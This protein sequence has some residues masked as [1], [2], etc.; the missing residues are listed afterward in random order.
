MLLCLV[1]GIILSFLGFLQLPEGEISS[2]VLY[3]FN[4][5]LI[6]SGAIF[7]VKRHIKSELQKCEKRD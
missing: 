3:F 5:C 1:A 6:Y 4:E 2:C 7:G